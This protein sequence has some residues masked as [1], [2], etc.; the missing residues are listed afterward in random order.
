MTDKNDVNSYVENLANNISNE[1]KV[2]I[3]TFSENGPEK[4][5]GIEIKQYSANDLEETFGIKL[6]CNSCQNVDHPTPFNTMQNFTFC[7]FIK[8]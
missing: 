1:G 4:C 3:G 6:R 5:S 7:S 8:K 2:V